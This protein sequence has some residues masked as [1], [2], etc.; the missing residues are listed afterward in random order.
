M[1][2]FISYFSLFL[3][4]YCTLQYQLYI[5][6]AQNKTN[7][8]QIKLIKR[9]L[10][11][12]NSGMTFQKSIKLTCRNFY[13]IGI[14]FFWNCLGAWFC[15]KLMSWKKAWRRKG[16]KTT[17]LISG[18]KTSKCNAC[19]T[20]SNVAPNCSRSH[21]CVVP[22]WTRQEQLLIMIWTVI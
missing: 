13:F 1:Q 15:E 6:K 22:S 8:R 3:S 2:S 10:I 5:S 17:I 4:L 14:W 9:H 7:S 21:A 18:Y 16:A 20:L 12:A 11:V 19:F